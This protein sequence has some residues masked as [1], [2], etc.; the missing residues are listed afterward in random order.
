MIGISGASGAPLA[1]ELLK[2]LKSSFP[3]IERH[4]VITKGGQMTPLQECSTT[5]LED[6][7]TAVYDNQNIGASMF[8]L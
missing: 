1:M 8:C 5:D 4:V 7:S 3:Q 2:K 6:L